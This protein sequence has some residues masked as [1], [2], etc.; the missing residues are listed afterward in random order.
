MISPSPAIFG[1]AAAIASTAATAGA[2]HLGE[3][4]A[5]VMRGISRRIRSRQRM[6]SRL[7]K[8]AGIGGT[9]SIMFSA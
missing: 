9:V 8:S 4:V 5:P 6:P 2:T 1:T 3:R 7:S